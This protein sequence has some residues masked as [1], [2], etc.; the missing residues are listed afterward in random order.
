MTVPI[1]EEI[2]DMLKQGIDEEGSQNRLARAIGYTGSNAGC[3]INYFLSG[4]RDSIPEDKLEKLKSIV[5]E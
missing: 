5:N 4:R 1:D 3:Q 2:K